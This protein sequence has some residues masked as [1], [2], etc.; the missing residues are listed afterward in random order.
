MGGK[1]CRLGGV[2][3]A[4]LDI[5]GVTC[6]ERVYSVLS[7]DFDEIAVSVSRKCSDYVPRDLERIVDWPGDREH[8]GVAFAI[9]ACLDWARGRN[10]DFIVT[11]PVDTPFI[12]TQYAVRL[13]EAYNTSNGTR[14][15]VAQCGGRIHGLHALWPTGCLE[16]LKTLLL[17]DNEYM[18]QRLHIALGS[19]ISVFEIETFDPFMNINTPDDLNTARRNA[20]HP[21]QE[22]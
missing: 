5:G 2:D 18:I 8:G 22:N 13:N 11:T 3:K 19:H 16:K 17:E 15:I 21:L 9:L 7:R 20:S 14:P 1:A 12:D 10:L 4:G 6:F